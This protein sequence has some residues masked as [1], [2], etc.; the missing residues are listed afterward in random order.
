VRLGPEVTFEVP[1]P[2]GPQQVTVVRGESKTATVSL[3][4]IL[5]SSGRVEEGI[6][7]ARRGL[8]GARASF[9][10]AVDEVLLDTRK[11]F[12]NTLRAEAL[13]RAAQQ[14][15]RQASEHLRVARARFEAQAV[16]QVEV[17]RA[18]VELADA[19]YQLSQAERGR[20]LALLALRTVMNAPAE[21]E[22]ELVD[23]AQPEPV[24][25]SVEQCIAWARGHRKDLVALR[26]QI[27]GV[28]SAAKAAGAGAL[29]SLIL[30]AQ[31][32]WQQA[33]AFTSER[34]WNVLVGFSVPVFDGYLARSQA[35]GLERQ[36]EQLLAQ[37][38]QVEQGIDTQARAAY[39]SMRAAE[40]QLAAAEQARAQANEVMRISQLRYEAGVAPAYEVIDAETALTAAEANRA[41]ALYD[42]KTAQAELARAIGAYSLRE[43]QQSE[44]EE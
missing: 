7:A 31:N 14:R 11:A 43:V 6:R 27:E 41:N 20:E 38:Q 9:D 18:E 29:P 32:Q 44:S 24:A 5:F 8:E 34:S 36:A 3:S 42:L 37:A 30:N 28:R 15:L 25:C 39:L 19:Q 16:P 12:Y 40:R 26:Y 4:Q 21:Q 23:E 35:R 13:V 33:T 2:V 17:L 22:I 1:T 10:N